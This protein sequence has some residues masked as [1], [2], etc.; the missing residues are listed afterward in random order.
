MR[1]DL[2]TL[3]KGVFSMTAL[4]LDVLSPGRLAQAPRCD[5]ADGEEQG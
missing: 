2:K 4:G 5:H 1:L 3:D